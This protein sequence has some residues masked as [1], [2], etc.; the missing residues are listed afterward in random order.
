MALPLK[1]AAE[2][3]VGNVAFTGWHLGSIT[4]QDKDDPS[5]ARHWSAIDVYRTDR[6]RFVVRR[7]RQRGE[8]E[9]EQTRV[10]AS[11]R[12]AQDWLGFGSLSLELFEQLGWPI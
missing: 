12:E 8:H 2:F 6:G 7:I 4:S 5:K 10:F 11:Q 3:V 1:Q 9:N